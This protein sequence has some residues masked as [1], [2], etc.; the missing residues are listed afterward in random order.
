M[1]YGFLLVLIIL[2]FVWR[3]SNRE[4]DNHSPSFDNYS[5]PSQSPNTNKEIGI[6]KKKGYKEFE[7]SV[8]KI[9]RDYNLNPEKDSGKFIGYM[10]PISL[11]DTSVGVFRNEDNKLLGTLSNLKLRNSIVEWHSGSLICWGYIS[12][13]VDEWRYAGWWGQV[14][15]YL[16]MSSDQQERALKLL[17]LDEDISNKL[18]QKDS[19]DELFRAFKLLEKREKDYAK[20]IATMQKGIILEVL[21]YVKLAKKLEEGKMW[22]KLIELENSELNVLNRVPVRNRPA[23]ESRL[24]KAK[25]LVQSNH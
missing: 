18:E 11:N 10:K 13:I 21:F 17:L 24:L 4:T 5:A 6:Y 8:R 14:E 2:F 1:I 23:F 19:V 20:I 15:L 16:G 3:S 12:H 7:L 9:A 25:D 22:S